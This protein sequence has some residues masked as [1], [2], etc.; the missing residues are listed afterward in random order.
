MIKTTT[1]D[2]N[3]NITVYTFDDLNQIKDITYNNS[4]TSKTF[5]NG[6]L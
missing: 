4:K 5:N 2:S 1:T 3:G 6:L